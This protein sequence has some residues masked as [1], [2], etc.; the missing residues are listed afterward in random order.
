MVTV[1]YTIIL[2]SEDVHRTL[3]V[4]GT[5]GF[6]LLVLSKLIGWLL[7][8]VAQVHLQQS[9]KVNGFE[10]RSLWTN[11]L[12]SDGQTRVFAHASWKHCGG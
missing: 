5:L 10:I 9:H 4:G 11:H 6:V 2:W 8:G 1:F 3:Y 7:E 12:Q